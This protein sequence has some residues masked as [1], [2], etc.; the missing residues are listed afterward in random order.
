M[1]DG[2]SCGNLEEIASIVICM[3]SKDLHDSM[4]YSS[5]RTMLFSCNLSVL[6]LS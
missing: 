4:E 2:R 3:I 6:D 1:I 5:P